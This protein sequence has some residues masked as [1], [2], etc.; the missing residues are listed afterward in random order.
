MANFINEDVKD[1][2]KPKSKKEIVD[3]LKERG[4]KELKISYILDY[5]GEKFFNSLS[6]FTDKDL[7]EILIKT[8]KMYGGNLLME[9][10]K[11][12]LIEKINNNNNDDW[13][14]TE[15]QILDV[16]SNYEIDKII[17]KLK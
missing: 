6:W 7:F 16:M 15:K 9:E 12:Y 13:E 1:F 8:I 11:D 10:I 14:E 3:S 5:G 17:D 4:S 2:L